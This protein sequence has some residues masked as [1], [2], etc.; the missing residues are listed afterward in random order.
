MTSVGQILT[1]QRE[2]LGITLSEVEKNIKIRVKLLQAIE[3]EDW[4]AF[5]SKFYISGIIKKYSLFLGLDP[6]KPLAFFRRDYERRESVRFKKKVSSSYLTSETK[7]VAILFL[8]LLCILFFGYFAYQLHQFL[9]PPEISLFEPKTETFKKTQKILIIGK[10]EKDAAVSIFGERVFQNKDGIFEYQF[11]LHKGN[12]VLTV[13]VVGANG[14]RTVLK[15]VF[16][17]LD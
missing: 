9:S 8:S 12:N 13:E 7:K 15:K 17:L 14:K 6:K 3:E 16:K 4:S 5:N 11:P 10:T 2:K 1:Q